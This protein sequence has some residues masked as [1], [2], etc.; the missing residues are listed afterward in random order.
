MIILTSGQIVDYQDTVDE[1]VKSSKLPI[2]LIFV[3]VG[4]GPF[5]SFQKIDNHIAPLWS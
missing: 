3:G 4:D 1:I 5:D 2:S